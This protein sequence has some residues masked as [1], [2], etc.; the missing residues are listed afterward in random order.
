MEPPPPS[1]WTPPPP[2]VVEWGMGL[3]S[4]GPWHPQPRKCVQGLVVWG[5]EGA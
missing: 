3:G 5:G 4:M 2:G 1:A